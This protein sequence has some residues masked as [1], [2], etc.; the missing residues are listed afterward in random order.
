MAQ[1]YILLEL[2]TRFRIW[3]G[4]VILQNR[5]NLSKKWIIQ[6]LPTYFIRNWKL[7]EPNTWKL[8]LCMKLFVSENFEPS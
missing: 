1:I 4:R 2:L 7:W 6:D 5:H 8:H 3:L